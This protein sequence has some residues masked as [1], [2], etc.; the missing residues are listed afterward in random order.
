MSISAKYTIKDLEVLSNIKSHTIRIWEKRYHI[1]EPERTSTN[2]RFYTNE[3][4]KK[5]LTVSFLNQHGYKISKIADM[6]EL[7]RS[8]L[9]LSLVQKNR[10]GDLYINQMIIAMIDLDESYFRNNLTQVIQAEGLE[11]AVTQVIYPFLERIGVMWQTGAILPAQEHFISNLIRHT[12]ISE[13]ESIPEIQNTEL[14]KILLLLPGNEMHEIALLLYHYSLKKRGYSTIYL[15]QA[16]PLESLDRISEIAHPQILVAHLTNPLDEDE[17]QTQLQYFQ[18]FKGHVFLS[19]YATQF[20]PK[21]ESSNIHIVNN[22]TDLLHQ[23][24]SIAIK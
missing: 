23:V 8:Q 11:N 15:G 20:F 1:L 10:E 18:S 6:S 22:L 9:L 2:I 7:E 12:I 17:M 16:V 19:G 5:L 3:D 4:L 14:P 24:A 21:T 13:I